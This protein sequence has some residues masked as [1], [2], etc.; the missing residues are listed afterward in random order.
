MQCEVGFTGRLL[1]VLPDHRSLKPNH[2]QIAAF[3]HAC[4]EGSFSRAAAKLGVTQSSITQHIAKLERLMGTQ[5]FLR[6]RDGLELTAAG[7]ELFALTDRLVT[8]EQLVMEKVQDYGALSDGNLRIIANAPRPVLP[9]IAH[10]N[11]L[12]PNIHIDFTLFDWTTA[13]RQLH[14]RRA[15]IGIVTEP[16]LTE[17]L[18]A[19]EI[20]LT[21]YK[22]YV[23]VDHRLAAR[24]QVS[25]ADL[26]EETVILPEFGSLTLREMARAQK[27]SGIAL[28]RIIRTTTFP[29]VKE[30]VLHGA[31]VGI[32]LE[33]CLYPSDDLV[34]LSILEM[35][36]TYRN[37]A[38]TPAKKERLRLTSSFLEVL[39][40][41]R[42]QP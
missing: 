23:R 11:R 33:D 36:E 17:G 4:H 3:T 35:P 25:L 8:L 1:R 29:V 5:L 26:V 2:Y 31:G 7:R 40:E 41:Y 14:E 18:F 6:L 32:L 16:T 13:M 28:P 20:G 38:V 30:A 42:Q 19:E 34:A 27:A 12:Y 24:A 10:Y 15:D 39:R 21:R 22:A 9:I 37:F